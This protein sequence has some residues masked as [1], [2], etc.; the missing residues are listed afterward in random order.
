MVGPFY[1]SA[2]RALQSEVNATSSSRP[3]SIYL[4]GLDLSRFSGVRYETGL[5][6]HLDTK[7]RDKPIGLIVALGYGALDFVLRWREGRWSDVPVVFA[8]VDKEALR[9]LDIPANVTGLTTSV[10]FADLVKAA[11]AVV[12]GLQRIAI[13]GDAWELQTAYRHLKEEI[14]RATAGLE[15]I[16]LMGFPMRELKKRVA[17]LP[18]DT[19]I[20][21]ISI[22]SD[23]KGTTYPPIDALSFLTAVA[24]RPTVIAAETFLG[25]GAV[26]GYAL[27]PQAVGDGAGDL[28]LRILDGESPSAIPIAAGNA[29]RPIFDW[30]ELKRWNVGESRLPEGSDIR[31][32]ELTLW[33]QFRWRIVLLV[34]VVFLQSILIVSL[35]YEDRRRR[36]AESQTN[37]LM[38]ELTHMNRV[39]TAGQL[40]ASIAHEIRQPLA[41]IVF[42]GGAGLNWLA[43]KVPDLGEVRDALTAIVKEGHRADDVIKNIRAMFRNEP[44][45]RTYVDLNELVRQVL[46]LTTRA[47]E[48]NSIALEIDLADDPEP[49]VSADPVQV[50][51]VILNLILNAVE[52]MGSS[53]RWP[54]VLRL[55]TRANA[56]EVTLTV[57]DSGPG[58][59]PKMTDK[60]FEPFLTTK[61]G[62]MGMGL[63]ICRS[64]VDAHEGKLT[65]D[66][67]KPSGAI[68]RVGLPRGNE[69]QGRFPHA[70][71]SGSANV[72]ADSPG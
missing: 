41:A 57:T 18:E 72:L 13:V 23:G 62:G 28:A 70:G 49:L 60:M 63:S 47:I 4:E 44:T 58:I 50:Q 61:P 59:D 3:V 56:A 26:G 51:Q 39:A 43:N 65:V 9:S 36:R 38:I 7:F 10:R 30:R 17:A 27:I 42:S 34:S 21:Y 55:E 54:R 33:E 8:M 46:T 19:A 66:S 25:Q 35:L 11:H 6:A 48:S 67:A 37:E 52:A 15:I 45:P 40:A 14:P 22:F 32:R 69:V 2:Y 71:V 20:I 5:K 68:F 1:F 16:D 64:I 24:N 31:F 12:P 29:V 53:D